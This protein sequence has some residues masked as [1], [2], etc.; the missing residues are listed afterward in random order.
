MVLR[1]NVQMPRPAVETSTPARQ[2]IA[3]LDLRFASNGH[4]TELRHC[5]H[6][7]PLRVQRLFHP[8]G[9]KTA[10]CYLLHPPGGVVLGDELSINADVK[11]G[12]ALLTST[13]AA[14]FYGTG[15]FEQ[16]QRQTIRLSVDQGTL[17]WLP[18]ETILFP[19]ANAELTTHVEFG[20]SAALYFWDIVVLGLPACGERFDCGRLWQTLSCLRSG[21]PVLKERLSINAGDSTTQHE[22]GLGGRSTL[23]TLVTTHRLER[24]ERERW[25]SRV[26]T[27]DPVGEFSITEKSGLLI[28][29]YRGDDA[30]R[31]RAGFADLW[32]TTT[33]ISAGLQVSEP[34]IWH[35]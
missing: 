35:T 22:I 9:N 34:R 27:L 11:S 13:S 5:A 17:Q 25:L 24:A 23:G 15:S 26:A 19:G 21:R 32:K 3:H 29:R 8:D 28:A 33:K 31:C 12:N 1:M 30:Q 18:Q 6:K 4:R 7:G 14:R 2:W 10:H 20:D 16:P